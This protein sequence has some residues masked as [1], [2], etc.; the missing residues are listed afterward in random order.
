MVMGNDDEMKQLV[1]RLRETYILDDG[2][3]G[4]RL[5]RVTAS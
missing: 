1:G 4:V 2:R 3:A 5:T